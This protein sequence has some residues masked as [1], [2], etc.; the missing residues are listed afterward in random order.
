[1]LTVSP[2]RERSPSTLETSTTGPLGGAKAGDPEVSTINARKHQ[3]WAPWEVPEL[4]VRDPQ[5]VL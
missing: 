4:V 3:R 1:M 5:D 2:L